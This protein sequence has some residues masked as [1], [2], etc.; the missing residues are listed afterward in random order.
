MAK[1]RAITLTRLKNNPSLMV[2]KECYIMKHAH[3]KQP[4]WNTKVMLK[5]TLSENSLCSIIESY[6]ELFKVPYIPDI[7]KGDVVT[8]QHNLILAAH[9]VK[10]N[11]FVSRELKTNE[12]C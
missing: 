10:V 4:I 6:K 3:I 9:T 8:F 1:L 11:Q 5:L 12:L 7:K 2:L